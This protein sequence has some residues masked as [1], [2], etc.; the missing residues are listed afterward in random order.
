MTPSFFLKQP[1]LT[2]FPIKKNGNKEIF[3]EINYVAQASRLDT[4]R[5]TAGRSAGGWVVLT[6]KRAPRPVITYTEERSPSRGCKS[7]QGSET[8]IKVIFGKHTLRRKD[9]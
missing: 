2:S 9:D 7:Y 3:R 4:H 5:N 6:H 8:A 1:N